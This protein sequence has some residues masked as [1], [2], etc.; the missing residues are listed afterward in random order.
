MAK[1]ETNQVQAEQPQPQDAA[2]N[3]SL[4]DLVTVA[5]I[6]QITTQ[7][8]AFRAEELQNVGA[9]YNKLVAFL[10]SAGAIQRSPEGAQ[11]NENA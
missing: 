10:E 5:Q 6:I 9:L 2:P 4:Q 1:K 11:E 8:G 7:R 3:L